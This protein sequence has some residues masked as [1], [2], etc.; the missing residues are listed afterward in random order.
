MD[1]TYQIYINRVARLTLTATYETQ[2]ENIQKSPKFKGNEAVYFPGYSIITPLALEDRDNTDFYDHLGEFQQQLMEQVEPGLII[3]VPPDSFHFTVA[4]LIWDSTYKQAVAE[5]TNFDQQ[6]KD[7]IRDSFQSYQQVTI[8]KNPSQWQILGLLVFPRSLVVGLVPKDEPSYQQIAQLRRSIYQNAGLMALGI[9]QRYYFTAH[10]TL[11]YFGEIS[12]QFKRQDLA[13]LLSIF[14]DR[15]LE[16]DPQILNIKEV[17][18]RK[19]ADM[20]TFHT[21]EDTPKIELSN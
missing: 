5:R 9:D 2:L 13:N 7:C 4:D 16:I 19:F 1:E 3:P 12:S 6:L 11:G 21:E 8:N 15:W 14:N 17:Q 18:L 20:I 10:I